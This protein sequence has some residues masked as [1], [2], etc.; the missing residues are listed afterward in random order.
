MPR[1]VNEFAIAKVNECY[2]W[3]ARATGGLSDEN[4]EYVKGIFIENF[5]EMFSKK[6]DGF[7]EMWNAHDG[8]LI[9]NS[10]RLGV[11]V[12]KSEII[13]KEVIDQA[14]RRL[15]REVCGVMTESHSEAKGG[16]CRVDAADAGEAEGQPT[17][18]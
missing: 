17:K 16:W 15:S 5:I 9:G 12:R 6:P 7:T 14:I 3:F 1:D 10:V 11:Y 2:E 18:S 8:F 13:T 4:E